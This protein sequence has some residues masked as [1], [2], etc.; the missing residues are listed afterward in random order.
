MAKSRLRL[1][2]V[3]VIAV[4]AL[5][6]VA[7]AVIGDALVSAGLRSPKIL[8][9][10]ILGDIAADRLGVPIEDVVV[11]HGDTNV[12]HYGRDTYGSRGT[13]VGGPAIV[14]C[15][16]K[17]IAKGKTLAAHLF[18]ALDDHDLPAPLERIEE[19]QHA[20]EIRFSPDFH[21]QWTQPVH[22]GS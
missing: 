12:A 18:E 7:P 21:A 5:R 15:V 17:I 9:L 13:A 8:S 2:I 19:L 6:L 22:R 14:M 1:A 4:V 3:A 20:P 16:D 10:P 11:L